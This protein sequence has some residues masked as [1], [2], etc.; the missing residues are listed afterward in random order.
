MNDHSNKS[1]WYCQDGPLAGTYLW[2]SAGCTLPFSLHG[3]T[4]H[5]KAFGMGTL[6]WI[7]A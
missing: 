3:Q 6:S 5:Y 4:G 7:P 1:K 2:L